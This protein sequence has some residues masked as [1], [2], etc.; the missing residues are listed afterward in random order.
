[1]FLRKKEYN[2]TAKYYFSTV[3]YIYGSVSEE[4]REP[5]VQTEDNGLQKQEL[6]N[7]AKIWSYDVDV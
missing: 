6:V 4:P 2:I 5:R 1:V 7:N 3:K